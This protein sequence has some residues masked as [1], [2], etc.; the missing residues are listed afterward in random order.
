MSGNNSQKSTPFQSTLTNHSQNSPPRYVPP[1][2]RSLKSTIGKLPSRKADDSMLRSQ[3]PD[4]H[5]QQPKSPTTEAVS[6]TSAAITRARQFNSSPA[7]G[8]VQRGWA[9]TFAP[10]PAPKKEQPAVSNFPYSHPYYLSPYY[11]AY[12]SQY[13]QYSAPKLAQPAVS[14]YPYGHPYFSSPYYNPYLNQYSQYSA[15]KPEQSAVNHYPYGHPYLWSS[16]YSAYPNQYSQYYG[17]RG[18]LTARATTGV[19]DVTGYSG[20]VP[21]PSVS[22]DCSGTTH[23]RPSIFHQRSIVF[24]DD[25]LCVTQLLERH[26]KRA[27][28]KFGDLW[29][30]HQSKNLGTSATVVTRR[31]FRVL[32]ICLLPP[33]SFN[34]ESDT[35]LDCTTYDVGYC[36]ILFSFKQ[37]NLASCV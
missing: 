24:P 28:P 37:P 7:P 5:L 27:F 33:T 3:S 9:S 10:A 16:Y 35:W 4:Q 18:Q 23:I 13:S 12:M 21:E 14:D 22:L 32:R 25:S 6:S 8:S 1:F 15:P 29:T 26:R 11:A 20:S 17:P 30:Q 31:S 36:E 2:K 34:N 19:K